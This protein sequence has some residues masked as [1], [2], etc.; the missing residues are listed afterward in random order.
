MTRFSLVTGV[1]R[2]PEVRETLVSVQR[3]AYVIASLGYAFALYALYPTYYQWNLSAALRLSE[4]TTGESATVAGYVLIVVIVSSLVRSGLFALA[5]TLLIVTFFIPFLILSLYFK[6]DFDFDQTSLVAVASSVIL[7][8]MGRAVPERTHIE[9]GWSIGADRLLTIVA[10]ISAI[11]V[12]AILIVFREIFNVDAGSDVFA[13]RLTYRS[14]SG[15]ISYFVNLQMVVLS[16]F[17]LYIG[18]LKRRPVPVVIA[19][20][21]T[22]VIFF[23]TA[24]RLSLAIFAVIVVLSV[25]QS[26]A[27]LIGCKLLI[28]A[29]ALVLLV[30]SYTIDRNYFERPVIS[31]LAAHR[32]LVIHGV[33]NILAV[34][35]F[36]D[37]PKAL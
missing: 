5:N 36:S 24:H 1:R 37:A 6:P 21:A 12:L 17:L 16:P 13:Q 20:V 7:S 30:G 35:E 8:L 25:W 19:T 33:I 34:E 14:L 2:S 31:P 18:I 11:N 9:V 32:T 27:R 3:L 28:V 23:V 15:M 29:S 10:I 4:H 26:L 22:A